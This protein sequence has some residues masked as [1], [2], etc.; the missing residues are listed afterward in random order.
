MS[1]LAK[2]RIRSIGLISFGVVVGA[3]FAG[4]LTF[5]LMN[6][7][8]KEP[9]DQF[10]S[11]DS[12]LASK[13]NEPGIANSGNAS[14]SSVDGLIGI[15]QI[16]SHFAKQTAL[17]NQVQQAGRTQLLD[18]LEQ[19]E[20]L[21]SSNQREYAVEAIVRRWAALDPKSALSYVDELLPSQRTVLTSTV[22]GEWSSSNLDDAV[23]YAKSLNDQQKL[24]AL[25]GILEVRD[26]LSEDLQRE[27]AKQLGNEQ[28]AISLKGEAAVSKSIDDPDKA[29]NALI[30]DDHEDIGQLESFLKVAKTLID[31]QGVRALNQINNS[32]IEKSTRNAILLS[33]LHNAAQ[34]DP[35]GAFQEAMFLDRDAQE[36]ALPA[37][38][39]VW[40]TVD[41]MVAFAA[42]SN[43][44]KS[45]L[46][47]S[48]QESLI[49]AWAKNDPQDVFDNLEFLPE[50]LRAEGEEQAMLAIARSTPADAVQFLSTMEDMT[51]KR[52]LAKTIAMNWAQLDVYEALNWATSSQLTD[53]RMRM[54]VLSIVLSELAVK[55][56]ELAFQTALNQPMGRNARGFERG[57]EADVIEQ[58]AKIDLNKAMQMLDLVREG[59]T[60]LDAYRAVGRELILNAEYDQALSLGQ[61]LPEDHRKS[62]FNAVLSLWAREEPEQM[63]ES[64]ASISSPELK[65]QAAIN[66]LTQNALH[67]KVLD[68]D[69]VEELTAHLGG[70]T[71]IQLGDGDVMVTSRVITP[72]EMVH[73]PASENEL[74]VNGEA[75]PRALE[76][77]LTDALGSGLEAAI[78]EAL[79]D[80]VSGE[81]TVIKSTEALG[82]VISGDATVIKRI[83]IEQD[84]AEDSE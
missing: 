60:Q 79:G 75:L 62:Y 58:V 49:A 54:D 41:P 3:A 16:E 80:V 82:D 51:R 10:S 64:I 44:N 66:L 67:A 68:D 33:V 57:L 7:D 46:R 24:A 12:I 56:P 43:L 36:L 81:A 29:W 70:N 76:S 22:F 73:I 4:L 63:F 28:Y 5:V 34:S 32:L 55:D 78:T 37:I 42:V 40:A 35:Q 17:F 6:N 18:L 2:G 38:I 72:G 19:A 39:E 21:A 59:Y 15:S 83:E 53:E 52:E 31:Q 84:Y 14:Q 1:T 9:T 47:A 8:A 25:Q 13:Q 23:G 50:R 69:Q 45:S 74:A 20:E 48:L 26:D 11:I 65:T 71:F 30:A 61:R 77:A 27:V